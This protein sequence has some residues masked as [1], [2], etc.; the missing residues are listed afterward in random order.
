M[1]ERE[2]SQSRLTYA[3]AFDEPE[4]RLFFAGLEGRLD[5]VSLRSGITATVLTPPDPRPV[6]RLSALDG[7]DVAWTTT[8]LQQGQRKH[9]ERLEVW[10]PRPKATTA[11]HPTSRSNRA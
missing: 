7:G 8:M 1:V 2:G 6:V 3:I 9:A 11:P 4:E 5:A 10:N